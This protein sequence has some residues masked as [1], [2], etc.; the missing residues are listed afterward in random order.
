[1]NGIAKKLTLTISIIAVFSLALLSTHQNGV[2]TDLRKN[3]SK[4]EK[5]QK[6]TEQALDQEMERTESLRKEL[7]VYRDSI[8]AFHLEITNLEKVIAEQK[9]TVK[10]LNANIQK[11]DQKVKKLT[12]QINQLSQEK[13]K[14]EVKIKALSQERDSVLKKM[15]EAD[16]E[17]IQIIE[18][19]RDT[20]ERKD[21][22]DNQL[23][24]IEHRKEEA[25]RNLKEQQVSAPEFTVNQALE[26]PSVKVAP[27][28]PENLETTKIKSSQQIN[29]IVNETSVQYSSITLKSRENSGSLRK[30]R[31]ND[32]TWRYTYI[33]FD[34]INSEKEMIIGETFLIQ[35]IDLDGNWV[36]PMNESNPLYPDSE[37]G[38][39]GLRFK[40]E[41]K[42][43]SLRY[44]NTQ[45]KDGNNYGIRILYP[46]DNYLLPLERSSR[47]IV[48]NGQV[49][50]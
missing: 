35:I 31:G 21:K 19:K 13:R 7:A 16:R 45:K 14:N 43:V 42:P 33:D 18:E 9:A 8:E 23:Q 5:K 29:S 38:A 1:M 41:G 34:L 50:R 24:A 15:E 25:Q 32:N 44:F 3:L 20:E 30:I 36:V 2:I 37:L 6:L 4:V 48:E 17:R 39:H 11:Q 27:T 28:I 26:S 46:R 40:Y 49:V 47:K 22:Q 12:E 10:K